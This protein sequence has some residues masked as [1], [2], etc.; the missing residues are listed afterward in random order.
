[1]G[2]VEWRH[3]GSGLKAVNHRGRSEALVAF[4]VLN[5]A[6]IGNLVGMK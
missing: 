6:K 4:E 1:M 2:L 3:A 5:C